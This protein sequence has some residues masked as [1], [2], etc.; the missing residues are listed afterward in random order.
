VAK[1]PPYDKNK[2]PDPKN[3]PVLP[4]SRIR[5]EEDS[6]AKTS[7]PTVA[8]RKGAQVIKDKKKKGK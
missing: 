3:K 8:K 7:R 2:E 4:P 1:D 5:E 6:R